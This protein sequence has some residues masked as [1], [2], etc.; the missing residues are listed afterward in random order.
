[1]DRSGRWTLAWLVFAAGC[2]GPDEATPPVPASVPATAEPTATPV[3]KP[4]VKIEPLPAIE[5][6]TVPAAFVGKHVLLT[7][8]SELRVAPH[9]DA[10]RLRLRSAA[11]GGT[12]AR[13][14]EVMAS[15]GELLQVRPARAEHRCDDGLA[16]LDPI[17]PRF[18]V[19][20]D[21]VA[22]VLAR[23]QSLQHDDGTSV[24]LRVG[25]PVLA[26]GDAGAVDL[27]GSRL[28]IAIDPRDVGNAFEP[29]VAA[30]PPAHDGWLAPDAE[31]RVGRERIGAAAFHVDD[32]GAPIVLARTLHGER[33]HVDLVGPCV[34]A[35]VEV[36]VEALRERPSSTAMPVLGGLVADVRSSMRSGTAVTWADGTAAGKLLA[37]V[38]VGGR[39]RRAKRST[40]LRLAP[41]DRVLEPFE[42]C[43]ATREIQVIEPLSMIL[44]GSLSAELEAEL[45][46][47]L[48]DGGS[49]VSG[50]L[51]RA[52]DVDLGGEV[53]GGLGGAIGSAGGGGSL[54][55]GGIGD[56]GGGAAMEPSA[57]L[58]PPRSVVEL[59]SLSSSG[60]RD[61]T[62]TRASIR[63]RLAGLRRCAEA[64]S[65]ASRGEITLS[66]TITDQG[67][68]T[69][70]GVSGVAE[71][72]DCV[73]AE[74][75]RWRFAADGEATLE[76][77]L[78]FT[79]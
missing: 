8:G 6:I 15:A 53:Y 60:V 48:T 74:V 34:S 41:D 68:V 20:I 50:V 32:G 61:M 52:G 71:L 18:W 37:D 63:G 42:L 55:A 13:A 24:R 70:L 2:G 3:P 26:T 28:A 4:V 23:E 1:M 69:K 36:E 22:D 77:V 31:I 54:H 39:G 45:L 49:S 25:L 40:C 30:A 73:R 59:E 9:D 65:P 51:G 46:A 14:F 10:P 11:A 72:E 75:E 35:R 67:R 44:G 27:M 21:A 12:V 62:A 47:S 58:D 66:F 33:A 5:R 17:E 19:G 29:A 56:F 38:E 64:H 57:R 76:L 78:S 7:A 43:A 16:A 79:S